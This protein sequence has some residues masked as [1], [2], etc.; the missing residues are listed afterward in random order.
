M[1]RNQFVKNNGLLTTDLNFVTEACNDPLRL[2]Y[3]ENADI[4]IED[5]NDGAKLFTGRAMKVVAEVG[6]DNINL[7]MNANRNLLTGDQESLNRGFITV[8]TADD[9][10]PFRSGWV[11]DLRFALNM[12]IVEMVLLEKA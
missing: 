9:T 2:T 7:I 3:Q 8:N 1:I 10:I 6:F 11:Y 5:L 4:P 12:E